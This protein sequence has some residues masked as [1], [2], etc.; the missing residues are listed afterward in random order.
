[1]FCPILGRLFVTPS[2]MPPINEPI[3]LPIPLPMEATISRPSSILDACDFKPLNNIASPDIP[4]IAIPIF[5]RP[6]NTRGIGIAPAIPANTVKANPTA[7]MRV[8]VP[9]K[10]VTL[11]VSILS[12]VIA[13][14]NRNSADIPAIIIA[15]FASPR[16]T[17][18]TGI[19]PA[20]APNSVKARPI[21]PSNPIIPTNC[22]TLP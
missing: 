3:A 21:V 6:S 4:A 14:S 15:I 20:I 5:A 18:G 8:I 16:S 12:I 2:P 1:M 17:K 7:P 22:V 11:P 13:P 19:R 9:I 10:S